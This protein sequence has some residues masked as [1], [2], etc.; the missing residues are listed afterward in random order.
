MVRDGCIFCWSM[1]K[2]PDKPRDKGTAQ[3]Q[4]RQDKRGADGLTDADR[5]LWKVVSK[6]FEARKTTSD[7]YTLQSEM[8][9]AMA[10][11]EK[12]QKAA[13]KPVGGKRKKTS[14]SIKPTGNT[15]AVPRPTALPRG[16]FGTG[17]SMI[18]KPQPPAPRGRVAGVDRRT[19]ERLRRGQMP[20]EAR[21]DLHGMTQHQAHGALALFVRQCHAAGKR[22]ILVITGKGAAGRRHRIEGHLSGS[23]MQD[24]E[25]PGVLKRKLPM[26][27]K[28]PDLKPLVLSTFQATPEHG[29]S[30]AVYILLKRH[31]DDRT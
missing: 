17:L 14:K 2:T 25:P 10:A 5:R 18:C 31:R 23:M 29:G 30:G 11:A 20:I 21:L 27:L 8:T 28:E 26:W 9:A 12:D 24:R 6:Q 13:A 19:A 1:A 7:H 15:A 22:C 4:K 16:V 3:G